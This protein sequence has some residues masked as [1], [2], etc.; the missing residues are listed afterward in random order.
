MSRSASVSRVT[1]LV[2]AVRAVEGAVWAGAILSGASVVA[3]LLCYLIEVFMRYGLNAPTAWAS[4]FVTFF[5]CSATFLIMP[6][7]TSEQGHVAISVLA[8]RL[9]P[10][11]ETLGIRAGLLITGIICFYVG[12]LAAD[13]TSY[14]YVRGIATLS[15]VPV[16]KWLIMAPIVYGFVMSGVV[17]LIQ[18]VRHRPQETARC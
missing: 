13:Q 17:L 5:L 18:L 10:M 12:W 3:I 4:D 2:W 8:G 16:P 15:V 14:N 6:R 7:I 9:P 11:V 1:S